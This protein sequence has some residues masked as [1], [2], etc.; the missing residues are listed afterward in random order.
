MF[1][2][3]VT[4]IIKPTSNLHTASVIFLH[5]SGDTGKGVLN[6][7]QFLHKNF[8]LPHVKF[9]FPTAPLRPYTYIGGELSNVWF[10]RV[11]LSPEMPEDEE[12]LNFIKDE[13]KGIVDKEINDGIPL[14]RI[15][16]GGFSMG[17]ALSLQMAYR[18]LPGFAG[19]FALSSFLNT[20]SGVY[21]NFQSSNTPLFMCHGLKDEMVHLQ[22]GSDTYTKLS[23][24]GVKGN[25]KILSNAFHELKK[26]EIRQ[27]LT[28]IGT[29]LP[30]KVP[31]SPNY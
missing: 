25:F 21:S 22:W 15:I 12:G 30:E 7:V 31:E 27:L 29:I 4:E 8:S 26:D 14:N 6:W 2:L 1:K 23:A 24:L 5:G 10:D 18:F 17:G 11:N 20:N 19:A 28:W 9:L 13:I 3:G 16:I